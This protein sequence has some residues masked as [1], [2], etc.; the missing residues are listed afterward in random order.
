M[1]YIQLL[2]KGQHDDEKKL[3]GFVEGNFV[4]WMLK[5]KKIKTCLSWKCL[6]KYLLKWINVQ[7]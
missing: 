3:K 5:D 7:Q 6:G 2:H 4:L 1:N